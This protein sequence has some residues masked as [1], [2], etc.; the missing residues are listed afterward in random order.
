MTEVQP[1]NAPT[2]PTLF[3]CQQREFTRVHVGCSVD[4]SEYAILWMKVLTWCCVR[5]RFDLVNKFITCNVNCQMK[6]LKLLVSWRNVKA[7]Y[8]V[9]LRLRFIDHSCI[10]LQEHQ[11][12]RTILLTVS[13]FWYSDMKVLQWLSK[14][15][16]FFSFFSNKSQK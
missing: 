7:V 16:Y 3:L 4:L 14:R 1:N 9:Q 8:T 15:W 6:I 10:T 12:I 5:C 2:N 13:K 11:R